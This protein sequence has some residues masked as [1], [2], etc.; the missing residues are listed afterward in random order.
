MSRGFYYKR[1]A[2]AKGAFPFRLWS[3]TFVTVTLSLR[4]KK[5]FFYDSFVGANTGASSAADAF[6][7][8]DFVFSVSCAYS[9]Y[10]TFTFAGSAV[11]AVIGNYVCH[12]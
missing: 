3:V 9:A 12:N 8:V 10:W 4:T 5:L 2:P 6:V 7:S 11:D 1:K